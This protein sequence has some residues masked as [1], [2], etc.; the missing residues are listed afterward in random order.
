MS[1]SVLSSIPSDCLFQILAFV[2][3][4]AHIRLQCVSKQYNALLNPRLVDRLRIYHCPWPPSLP[5]PTTPVCSNNIN[6][7]LTEDSRI[8]CVTTAWKYGFAVLHAANFIV[9]DVSHFE[10]SKESSHQRYMY[11]LNLDT[12][13]MSD[14]IKC[15]MPY[16]AHSS[17]VDHPHHGHRDA[18]G[19]Q[20][21]IV[22]SSISCNRHVVSLYD[23]AEAMICAPILPQHH[24]SFMCEM[25]PRVAAAGKV[26]FVQRL[27]EGKKRKYSVWQLPHINRKRQSDT[28]SS[29]SL[30]PLTELWSRAVSCMVDFD[31]VI[32]ERVCVVRLAWHSG[33]AHCTG[34]GMSPARIKQHV[35][36][37]II[38][39]VTA[40]CHEAHCTGDSMLP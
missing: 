27:V 34:R 25:Q 22:N 12:S 2:E 13:Q 33:E 26:I 29:R 32:T 30:F 23:P 28:D 20:W 5:E 19:A 4:D 8:V 21:M 7:I 1:S 35:A 3:V 36:M 15:H 31:V 6:D 38:A 39:Q 17:I 9:I 24:Y 16:D 40:C 14:R 37:K 10:T 18:P 11:L